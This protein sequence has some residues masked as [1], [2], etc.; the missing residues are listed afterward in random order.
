[1]KLH[2]LYAKNKRTSDWLKQW[3][4][5]AVGGLC[6]A[7]ALLLL[8]AP[9]TD[10]AA[11]HNAVPV[12]VKA[13]QQQGVYTVWSQNW[14]PEARNTLQQFCAQYGKDSPGYNENCH[15]YAVFDFDNTTSIM[16]MEEQLIIWQ[17]D[18]LAFAIPP[19][20]METVLRTGI[21]PEKLAL[22]YGADDGKDRPVAI[23]DA[24]ADAARDYD[25]LYQQ[26]QVTLR[27]SDLDEATR[28]SAV[29]QDFKSKMRWLYD[30]VSE[31]MDNSVSYP[32][33]TYWFTNM[34]PLDV[35]TL[36]Y[37]CDAYYGNPA[38]GATWN[39]GTYNGAVVP[40][41]RAGRVNVSYKLG[42]TVTPEIKELYANF[43][44]NGIDVWINSASNIDVIRAAVNYFQIPGV[45]GIVAMTNQLDANQRYKNA[46]DYSLHPQTQGVGKALTIDKVIR[47]LYQGQ[48][49][50]FC[51]MDSQGDFN[52]CTE[53]KNT[54]AVLIMNRQRSDDAALC[55][56]I[57]V[58]QKKHGIS[59][60]QA[61]KNGDTKFI[62]QGRN[63]NIGQ[64]WSEDYTQLLGKTEPAF[65]SQKG[66]T[67][68]AQLE[69]GQSIREILQ[70]DTKLKDYKGYK[71]RR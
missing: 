12:N 47:S 56:G 60:A 48:G 41:S 33:V 40:D 27:G 24:I 1:M 70:Q 15:P 14:D 63:E 67:A 54:K 45:D 53:Y 64:L 30:A 35:Y 26:G 52:F 20:E 29:Y 32:W 38:K 34:T 10:A 65:L 23:G 2:R 4:K 69:K 9:L 42:I 7:F 68:L 3:I 22:T 11:A 31:T 39:K 49:P 71:S 50:V 66:E 28:N 25:I 19:A 55:A 62:L 46:Y 37:D 5:P 51:A 17:L 21:P 6:I 57:A 13:M 36:A 58:Y 18:H 61:N 8:N 43:E 44:K 59:L 16:D